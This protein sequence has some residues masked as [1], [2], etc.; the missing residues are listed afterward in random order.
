M[1]GLPGSLLPA[2][3]CAARDWN[4]T[5]EFPRACYRMLPPPCATGTGLSSSIIRTRGR[6]ASD[7]ADVGPSN[8][9][10]HTTDGSTRAEIRL[11]VLFQLYFFPPSTVSAGC[12]TFVSAVLF[13]FRSV[14]VLFFP[15]F[16]LFAISRREEFN[17][18]SEDSGEFFSGKFQTNA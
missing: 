3:A 17:F 8:E 9:L 16:F 6:F 15:P 13:F 1:P 10:C 5:S 12:T 4:G 11:I 14:P 2:G 18:F 7:P